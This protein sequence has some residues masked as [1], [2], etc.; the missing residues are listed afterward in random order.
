MCKDKYRSLGLEWE[1]METDLLPHTRMRGL[2]QIAE[3]AIGGRVP[4]LSTGLTAKDR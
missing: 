1:Y 3:K 2:L 4:V